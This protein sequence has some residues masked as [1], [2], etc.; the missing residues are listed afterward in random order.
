M[1]IRY[2]QDDARRRV[3]I[4][5]LADSTHE[6]VIGA[7]DRQAAEGA[8]SYAVLYD[9]RRSMR[10]P[11]PD[12]FRQLLLRVGELTARYGPR[13]PVAFVATSARMARLGRTYASVGELTALDVKVFTDI[14]DAARWLD[15]RATA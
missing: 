13:G 8:W 12:E 6:D 15:E 2:D 5:T 3:S 14:D 11:T 10:T 9:A 1:A 4:A 7:L